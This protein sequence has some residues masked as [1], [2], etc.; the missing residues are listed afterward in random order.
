MANEFKAAAARKK[1]LAEVSKAE[2]LIE[3]IDKLLAEH[4]SKL[5]AQDIEDG[6]SAADKLKDVMKDADSNIDALVA[7]NRAAED[8][9]K[10]LQESLEKVTA[11]EKNEVQAEEAENTVETPADEPVKEVPAE[12]PVQ[13]ENAEENQEEE[14]ISDILR[15]MYAAP[16]HYDPETK[17]R[18]SALIKPSLRQ[19][20][21]EDR[22]EKRIKSPNDLINTL[23]EIY[24]GDE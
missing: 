8:M 7:E 15:R 24:Y 6:R 1:R 9:L 12:T 21:E 11:Q 2:R 16:R 17:E 22:K 18:F 5:N 3:Q 10:K 20:M 19:K 13:E 14:K 4:E 23:L